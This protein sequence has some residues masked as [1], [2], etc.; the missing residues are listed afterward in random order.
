MVLLL[1]YACDVLGTDH[2]SSE[3]VHQQL[4]EKNSREEK[5][6][7]SKRSRKRKRNPDNWKRNRCKRAYQRG[8]SFQNEKGQDRP[9]KVSAVGKQLCY[10][11]CRKKCNENVTDAERQ[12]AA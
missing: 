6:C 8:D 4:V 12:N 11:N 9:G 7:I 10:K 3:R 2:E 1:L 5:S